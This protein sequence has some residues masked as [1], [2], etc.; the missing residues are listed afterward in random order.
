MVTLCAAITPV[1]AASRVPIATVHTMLT[2]S[3][4]AAADQVSIHTTDSIPGHSRGWGSQRPVVQRGSSRCAATAG[5]G[6]VAVTSLAVGHCCSCHVRPPLVTV[7]RAT[8]V[9]AVAMIL[10]IQQR[11]NSVTHQ[12]K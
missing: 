5:A 7:L 9:V 12:H 11:E 2:V 4:V 10:K 6:Q 8:G 3:G 1:T